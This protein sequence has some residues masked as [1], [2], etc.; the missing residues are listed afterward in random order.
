LT[1]TCRAVGRGSGPARPPRKLLRR[2][3]SRS[4]ARQTKD[5]LSK[6]PASTANPGRQSPSLEQRVVNRAGGRAEDDDEQ[7]RQDEQDQ[8]Y[9]HDRRQ[10]GG[11]LLGAHH[12]LVAEF[13]G[14]DAQRARQRGAVFLGL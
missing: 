2:P 4:R 11:L 6:S 5:A 13:G 7:H 9:G 12:P 3:A 10:P 8:R 14:E 1:S